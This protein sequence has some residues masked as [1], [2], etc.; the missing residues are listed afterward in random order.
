MVN[1]RQKPPIIQ[2]NILEYLLWKNT[3]DSPDPAKG[4]SPRFSKGS[5]AWHSAI[6]F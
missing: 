1:M 3:Q 6:K 2:A 5:T 4:N